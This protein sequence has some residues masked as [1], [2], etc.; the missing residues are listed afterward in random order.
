MVA[1]EWQGRAV[2]VTGAG[3]GVGRAVAL[4]LHGRGAE[5]VLC[6]IQESGLQETARLLEGPESAP[7]VLCRTDISSEDDVRRL[8]ETAEERFGRVDALI[9]C[10]AICE[11]GRIEDITSARWDRTMN[12]NLKG[13]FLLC[14]SAFAS[15]RRAGRGGSIVNFA[16]VAGETGSVRPCPDY[17]ASKGA[18]IAFSKSL[19]REGAPDGIRVNV[20]SPGP[21]DTPMLNIGSEAQRQAFAG[22]SP[23]GR[24]GTPRD[25]SEA[26]LFLA[27]S[28]ASW[29]TGEVL[30]VNGGSLM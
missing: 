9:H 17:A 3:S 20:V 22:R 14:R 10:A 26:A 24:M 25:L 13:T 4:A 30:R 11:E 5:L 1:D 19:A 29:I 27:S 15:M 2:I 28:R 12:V 8:F 21:V 23:L 6:D 16:S 18:V 7:V